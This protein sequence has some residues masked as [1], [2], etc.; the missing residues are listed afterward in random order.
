MEFSSI[1]VYIALRTGTYLK[2]NYICFLVMDP[3]MIGREVVGDLLLTRITRHHKA[4]AVGFSPTMF[5]EVDKGS[6]IVC[7]N[8]LLETLRYT[9]T[10]AVEDGTFHRC[11]VVLLVDEEA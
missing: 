1:Y 8:V 6:L 5:Q 7:N 3:K 2:I 11:G 10:R 4:V 9:V